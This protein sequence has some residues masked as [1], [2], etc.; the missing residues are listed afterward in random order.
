MSGF[1]IAYLCFGSLVILPG[2]TMIA[3]YTAT[4]P[5]WNNHVGRMMIAYAATEIAMS[6][7]LMLTIVT[8]LHPYWFRIAWFALQVNLGVC[9]SYQVRVIVKI[10]RARR[11]LA[12][13][14]KTRS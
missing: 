6:L 5:W 11:A 10:H 7:L 2:L 9:F 8:H 12:D 13:R 3:I 1:E 14:E 4:N